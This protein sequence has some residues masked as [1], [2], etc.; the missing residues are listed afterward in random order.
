VLFVLHVLFVDEQNIV[1]VLELMHH[2]V[3]DDDLNV[4]LVV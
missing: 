4:H 1:E 3:S 2:Y